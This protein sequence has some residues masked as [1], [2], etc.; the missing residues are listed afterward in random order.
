[1]SEANPHFAALFTFAG[2]A[3]R[4]R[5]YSRAGLIEEELKLSWRL[6]GETEWSEAVLAKGSEPNLFMTAI[7]AQDGGA[8]VEYFLLAA[9]RSG[10]R[11]T[12]ARVAPDDFYSFEVDSR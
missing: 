9:D 7:P 4:I 12:F 3:Q 8:T 11:E 2:L 6:R 10:R 1:M 5:D